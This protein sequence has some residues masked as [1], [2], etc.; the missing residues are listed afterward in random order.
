MQHAFWR[1]RRAR[2]NGGRREAIGGRG[3]FLCPE[4][5]KGEELVRGRPPRVEVRAPHL[6]GPDAPRD[7]QGYT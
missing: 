1:G 6:V 4:R 5:P 3:P 7:K 2:R